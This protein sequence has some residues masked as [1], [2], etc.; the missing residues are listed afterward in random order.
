MWKVDAS[1]LA[2]A[3]IWLKTNR[4]ANLVGKT[5]NN[6]DRNP[7]QIA[8]PTQMAKPYTLCMGYADRHVNGISQGWVAKQDDE[9]VHP[10]R[11]IQ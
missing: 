10:L 1:H 5:M 11:Q 6:D 4:I 7:K 3:K 9:A 8:Q 2:I